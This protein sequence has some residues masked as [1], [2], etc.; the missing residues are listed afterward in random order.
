MKQTNNAIKFLMA[1]YR[2]I[3]KNAYF[4]GMASAV[5]LTAGLAVAGGAQAAAVS[6]DQLAGTEKVEVDGS[7]TTLSGKLND[8]GT[9]WNAPITVTSGAHSTNALTQDAT[10]VTISGSGSLTIATTANATDGVKITA[11]DSN[12]LSISISALNVKGQADGTVGDAK[13]TLNKSSVSGT[14]IVGS[15]TS[16]ISLAKTAEV[17][18]AA[19]DA[20]DAVLAGSLQATGGKLNFSGAGTLKTYTTGNTGATVDV[21]VATGKEAVLNLADASGST[22]KLADGT[23]NVNSHSAATTFTV[24]NGTLE[25]GDDVSFISSGSAASGGIV[26]LDAKD[27]AGTNAVSSDQAVLK[28]SSKKLTTFLTDGTNIKAGVVNIAKGTV[29]LTDNVDLYKVFGNTKLVASATANTGEIVVGS[30]VGNSFITGNE[31]TI[32]Q[33]L[34]AGAAGATVKANTLNLTE[35]ATGGLGV[36]ET[37]AEKYVLTLATGTGADSAYTVDKVHSYDAVLEDQTLARHHLK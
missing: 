16:T 21:E 19:D 32:S 37:V 29:E 20:A 35:Q 9:S 24:Q 28:L 26:K 34:G 7:T 30:T 15:N 11:A 27:A 2:A 3:F 22:L 14:V 6:A 13:V 23:F 4:K 5:L 12:N 31:L 8:L 36:G 25:I 33:S 18:F 10:D 1:Q 17:V